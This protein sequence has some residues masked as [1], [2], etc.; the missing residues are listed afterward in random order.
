MTRSTTIRPAPAALAGPLELFRVGIGPSSSHTVGP[1]LAARAVAERLAALP[2]EALTVTLHGSLAATGS[3]HG[4]DRALLAG[5]AGHAPGTVDPALVAGLHANAHDGVAVG[6]HRL[7]GGRYRLETVFKA[8]PGHPN[9]IRFHATDRDG[10]TLLDAVFR[11]IGGGFV[12]EDGVVPETAGEPPMTY[13]SAAELLRFARRTG[14][15]AEVA[16]VNAAAQRPAAEVTAGLR[17]I[18]AAMDACI[19]RGMEAEGLLPGGLR[20]ARRAAGLARALRAEQHDPLRHAGEWL[21]V[22]AMAV[23]EENAAGSRIVTAPTNGAAGVVPAV[24]RYARV[25]EAVD[26]DGAVRFLLAAAA[27][28]ALVK[29]NASI[30]GAE[31]GC[32]GEV[33]AAAAMAAAGLAEVLG[34]RPAQVTNAA[35]IALEHHLGMTCDPIAGLVQIPCIERNAIAA[36]KAVAAARLAL[37][38]SGRHV[39]SLDQAIDAMRRTGAD[40]SD[41]YKETSRGGLAVSVPEC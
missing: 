17:E 7:G 25:Y 22:W 40:M 10:A 37:R 19:E 26:D 33:G 3:G 31:V 36:G 9:A 12:T 41:D 27:I 21:G 8:P 13:A 2:L 38:G 35:E 28:G 14:S 29:R 16:A 24:L 6:P 30:S 5:L 32:Q 11:S 34:G 20:V 15:V 18:A 4:T 39:V 23:N 1:M